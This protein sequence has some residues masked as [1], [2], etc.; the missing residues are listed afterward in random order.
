MGKLT[1]GVNRWLSELCESLAQN[2]QSDTEI[3]ELFSP[4]EGRGP[5]GRH[6]NWEQRQGEVTSPCFSQRD[7]TCSKIYLEDRFPRVQTQ[8]ENIYLL[9]EIIFNILT[10]S[11]ELLFLPEHQ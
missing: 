1:V 7:T 11:V 5:G 4:K 2:V 6:G 10:A 9:L 3:D 8:L